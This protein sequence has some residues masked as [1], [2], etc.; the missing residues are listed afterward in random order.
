MTGFFAR[1][2]YFLRSAA[3]GLRSSPVTSTIAVVTIAVTLVLVGAFALL[4]A[5]MQ[6]VMDRFGAELVLSAYLEDDLDAAAQELLAEQVRGVEGVER[7]EVIGK[8]QALERFRRSV[9]GRAA[10]LEG[11][12]ENPLPPSLEI[13][14]AAGQRSP[15]GLRR[16]V[17]R[18]EG[19]RGVADL[20]YGQEWVEGY[21]NAVGLVRGVGIVIGGVLAFSAL[22][23]VANT[24]RLAV[25]ARRDELDILLL[26]GASRSFVSL[27]FLLEGVVQGALGGGLALG[28][29][30]GGYRLLLPG[31]EDGLSFL[32]GY[33]DPAFL[34]RGG[35]LWM[36]IGGA[37]LGVLGSAAAVLQGLRS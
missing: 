21:A 11:L 15:E 24:I 31:L 3:L 20:G 30:Y 14:L 22:L 6:G 7:V 12:E 2:R 27:P 35:A 25:Y 36:V 37:V 17:E 19:L 32:L 8:E 9:G 5:N 29:L 34:G 33:A 16:V 10:L 4:V 13:V 18:V 23:I 1:L 26:V 28:L